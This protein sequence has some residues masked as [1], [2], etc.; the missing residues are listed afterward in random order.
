M[1][2]L[3]VTIFLCYFLSVYCKDDGSVN[4]RQCTCK[5][6]DDCLDKERKKFA[7]CADLCLHRLVTDSP[8]FESKESVGKK[9]FQWTPSPQP[10]YEDVKRSTCTQKE[11]KMIRRDE[12]IEFFHH[13]ADEKIVQSF[14]TNEPNPNGGGKSIDL[15]RHMQII[16]VVQRNFEEDGHAFAD[17]VRACFTYRPGACTEGLGCGVKRPSLNEWKT[18]VN[19]CKRRRNGLR[20][21]F[22]NCL[23][24]VGI[25]NIDCKS[26]GA[27]G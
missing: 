10:C 27:S 21:R 20:D 11:G 6:L 15:Q 17:C 22:C 13:M 23:N 25:E 12:T 18:S 2:K 9:C 24:K 26:E 7:P 5:Q 3:L 4:I 14:P 1:I 16:D 19:K 8:K